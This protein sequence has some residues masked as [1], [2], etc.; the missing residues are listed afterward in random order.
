MVERR[1]AP[2]QPKTWLRRDKLPFNLRNRWPD[3]NTS[4]FVVEM[5]QRGQFSRIQV[6]MSEDSDISFDSDLPILTAPVV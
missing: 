3:K 2:T 6:R 5:A 1:Q 4:D